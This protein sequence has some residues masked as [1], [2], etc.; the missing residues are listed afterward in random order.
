MD[1]RMPMMTMVIAILGI[2]LAIGVI[3]LLALLERWRVEAATNQLVADLRLAHTHASNELTDWRVVVL[4]GQK[5]EDDEPDYYLVKLKTPYPPAPS[6]IAPGTP[7][8][9]RYFPGNVQVTNVITPAG[10]LTD[11]HGAAYWAAPWGT[12]PTPVP[13]TKTQEFNSS[14][15]V[16]FLVSPSGSVCVTVDTN[17]QNRIVSRSATSQVRVEYDSDCNTAN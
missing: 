12:P 1:N 13:D 3:I 7:P 8:K 11:S 14:G 6:V 2:L 10:S 5:E 16:S 9:P 17:P 4:L 15:T